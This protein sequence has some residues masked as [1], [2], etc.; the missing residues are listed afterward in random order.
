VPFNAVKDPNAVLDYK[1]DWSAWL[2]VS[3]T[4][5]SS[6]WTVPAGITKQSDTHDTSSTTIWLTS[7][8]AG[9]TYMLVNEIVT[10]QGRTENRS[11]SLFLED[12]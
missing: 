12:R 3:E 2:A 7:G 4:I 11:L 5:T 6:T 1:F 9:I 10:N 8:T